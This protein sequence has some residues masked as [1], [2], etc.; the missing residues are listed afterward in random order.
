MALQEWPPSFFRKF[1]ALFILPVVLHRGPRIW[2]MLQHLVAQ[3]RLLLMYSS[4]LARFH[5]RSRWQCRLEEALCGKTFMLCSSNSGCIH[6]YMKRYRDN[7]YDRVGISEC[8]DCVEVMR[9]NLNDNIQNMLHLSLSL[10]VGRCILPFRRVIRSSHIFL[11]AD[12]NLTFQ[13]SILRDGLVRGLCNEV[14]RKRMNSRVRE[15]FPIL[16]ILP[17]FVFFGAVRAYS[18]G[19]NLILSRH[20]RLVRKTTYQAS[21]TKVRRCENNEEPGSLQ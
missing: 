14:L 20:L 18:A 10:V 17:S 8:Y 13:I 7:E 16:T 15:D 2:L 3:Y 19:P 4:R 9:T 21:I 5:C 1:A 6:R 12:T 11:D